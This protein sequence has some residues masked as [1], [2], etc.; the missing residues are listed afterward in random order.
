MGN[1]LIIIGLF[2]IYLS[3]TI[4]VMMYAEQEREKMSVVDYLICCI[5]VLRT[6]YLLIEV[7][8]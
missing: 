8:E 6:I 4:W 1:I 5:P 2:F 3:E 7:H